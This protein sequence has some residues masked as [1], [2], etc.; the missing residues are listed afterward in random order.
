MQFGATQGNPGL[1]TTLSHSVLQRDA[2]LSALAVAPAEDDSGPRAD[3][4]GV[5]QPLFDPGS[6]DAERTRHPAAQ[7]DR[8]VTRSKDGRP[9][10]DS[11][12]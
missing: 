6:A 11:A 1:P 7:P 12:D 3:R 4:G 8:A 5:L 10:P 9:R 2:V